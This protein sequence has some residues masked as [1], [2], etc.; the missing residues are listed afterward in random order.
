MSALEAVFLFATSGPVFY[1]YYA[2]SNVTLDKWMY[3]SNPKYPSP[4][5]VLIRFFA[6]F[7]FPTVTSVTTVFTETKLQL[8][9]LNKELR[10]LQPQ[11][12]SI[13]WLHF[14]N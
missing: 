8:P 1:Y 13:D 9:L 4:E 2:R 14:Y 11:N 12:L 3:K 10:F 6:L 5:K 7:L